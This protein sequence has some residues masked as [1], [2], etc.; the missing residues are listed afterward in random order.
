MAAGAEPESATPSESREL[1]FFNLAPA[2]GLEPQSQPFGS[3]DT[4]P[5][6]SLHNRANS[7]QDSQLRDP[8]E[9]SAG[10]IRAFPEH[11][12]DTI[13]HKKCALCVPFSE[14]EVPED[15]AEVVKRWERVPAAIKKGI[16]A[17]V[18]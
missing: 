2:V 3:S 13:M 17:M 11:G 9:G 5:T 10:H 14:G 1:R 8:E 12:K 18:L 4:S 6:E 7:L 16:L 15:L